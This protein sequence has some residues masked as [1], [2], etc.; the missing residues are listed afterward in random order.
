MK[1]CDNPECPYFKRVNKFAEYRDD[2]NTCSDCGSVLKNG[3]RPDIE[4][5]QEEIDPLVNISS[6]RDLQDAYLVRGKLESDGIRVF[7]RN[8]H[9]IGVQWLYS[10]ALGGVKLD[11]PESQAKKALSLLE[12]YQSREI[13]EQTLDSKIETNGTC[14]ACKSTNIQYYDRSRKYSAI[15]LIISFP[16]V[17]FGKR[18]KCLDCKHIWKPKK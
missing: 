2:I 3:E 5:E 1:H 10:T 8:E 16:L 4:Y 17:L 9:T 15:S 7:L 6:Y 14:P 13:A 11:V 18:Y 12:E